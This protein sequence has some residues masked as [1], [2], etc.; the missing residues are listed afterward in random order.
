MPT[1]MVSPSAC[2]STVV[3][4]VCTKAALEPA[5]SPTLKLPPV[6]LVKP[7]C[8]TKVPVVTLSA[9]APMVRALVT[10]RRPRPDLVKAPAAVIAETPRVKV[11]A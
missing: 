5:E 9:L 6:A 7:F 1:R 4:P 3:P 2:E 8:R 11:F 10:T